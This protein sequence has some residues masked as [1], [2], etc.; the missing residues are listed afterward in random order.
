MGRGNSMG[1]RKAALIIGIVAAADLVL[2]VLLTSWLWPRHKDA[3]GPG[4]ESGS[5][6][7]VATGGALGAPLGEFIGDGS[8]SVEHRHAKALALYIEDEIFAHYG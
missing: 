3:G 4:S 6:A 2:M 7:V 1:N 8:G 5:A